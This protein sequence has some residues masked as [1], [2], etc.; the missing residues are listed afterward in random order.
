METLVTTKARQMVGVVKTTG[1][2]GRK[3]FRGLEGG[4][5]LVGIDLG[6]SELSQ[7]VRRDK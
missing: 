3:Q 7:A 4:E 6:L 2:K 5:R 1:I